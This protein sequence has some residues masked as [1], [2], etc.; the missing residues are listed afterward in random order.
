MKQILDNSSNENPTKQ[1][2]VSS[3]FAKALV[4]LNPHKWVLYVAKSVYAS[5]MP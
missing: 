2:L 5:D 3:L 1:R 4:P